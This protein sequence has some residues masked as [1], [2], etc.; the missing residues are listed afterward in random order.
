MQ[1]R[2]R[3][4][5]TCL[6]IQGKD[7]STPPGGSANPGRI[8]TDIWFTHNHHR[9]VDSTIRWVHGTREMLGFFHSISR[10]HWGIRSTFP[11]TMA[12]SL[13]ARRSTLASA[14]GS[15]STVPEPSS[16]GIASLLAIGTGVRRFRRR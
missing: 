2:L 4:G 10:F 3:T 6:K 9:L 16:L 1:V 11:S 15:T 8:P 12:S 7:L 14:F 5:A 13:E